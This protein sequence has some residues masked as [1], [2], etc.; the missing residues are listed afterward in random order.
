MKCVDGCPS[1]NATSGTAS[2]T[3]GR[4]V[5]IQGLRL[6]ICGRCGDMLPV[7]KSWRR[8]GGRQDDAGRRAKSFPKLNMRRQGY[9]KESEIDWPD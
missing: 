3:P 5:V 8:V 6:E 9:D 1:D 2:R 7:I 4:T